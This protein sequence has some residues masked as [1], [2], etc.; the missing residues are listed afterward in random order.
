M[1]NSYIEYLSN[2]IDYNRIKSNNLIIINELK[3]YFKDTNI[4]NIIGKGDTARYID[5]GIGINQSIIFGNKDF[6]FC[7]DY[8]SMFG[9]EKIIK[10]IKYLFCPD[11]PH[12][13]RGTS[14]RNLTYLN[15]IQYVKKYN[16]TGKIF[17]YKLK[18][19]F[20]NELHNYA[21]EAVSTTNIAIKIFNKYLNKKIFNLYGIGVSLLYHDDIQNLDYSLSVQDPEFKHYIQITTRQYNNNNNMYNN[22]IYH[23][24]FR[25]MIDKDI[26]NGNITE[27]NYH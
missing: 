25:S 9:L 18:T 2:D 7:N 20:S 15:I 27:V 22:P 21:I 10:N 24:N 16:F 19:S 1:E 6:L 3:E 4:I 17:I 11:Y 8:G 14:N 12:N 5:N 23:G 13:H 26:K